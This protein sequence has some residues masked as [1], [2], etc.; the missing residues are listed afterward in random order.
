VDWLI[1]SLGRLAMAVAGVPVS[2][3]IGA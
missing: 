1:D 2:G 3:Q